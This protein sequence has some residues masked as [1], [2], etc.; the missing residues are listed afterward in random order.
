MPSQNTPVILAAKRT[1]LGAFNGSLASLSAVELGSALIEPLLTAGGADKAWIDCLYMGLVLSASV[2]QNPARQVALQGGLS[3]A[4][5][6]VTF[7]KVCGS[8]MQAI[9]SAVDSL[10]H[11]PSQLILAGGSESM[12]NTPYLLRKARTGYRL[13][14]DKLLDH[15]VT[16]GLE[17][18]FSLK[19][20][21]TLAEETA[22]TLSI[23]RHQQDM[24]TIQSG[25]SALKASREGL[26]DKERISLRVKD[27]TIT[28][29]ETLQQFSPQKIPHLPPLFHER[30][31]I[32]A[33]NASALADG[34]AMLM[35][36]SQAYAEQKRLQPQAKI[37]GYETFGDS[38]EKFITA[39]MGAVHRLLK[40]IHWTIPDVDLWEINEAF[41]IVPLVLMETFKLKRERINVFGGSTILGHPLGASGA[42]IL[43]T[44]LNA[45]TLHQL[46]R[47]VAAICIGGGEGMALALERFH[48]N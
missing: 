39:P 34:A 40:K 16:D 26:F 15:L 7:N 45:L 32:T 23:T 46:K 41:S 42:R 20:M 21:G 2:G 35:M 12:S 19:L 14:H 30:G 29:D 33:A 28:Q 10:S 1:P 27:R 9:F 36:T 18:A 48:Q 6:A 4:T 5:H 22:N 13:G 47:G 11:N 44:L 37:C 38:P 3:H 43:V 24:Y 8:G 31:T 25:E 17:D